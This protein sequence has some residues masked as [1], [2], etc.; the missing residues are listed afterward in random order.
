M[1]VKIVVKFLASRVRKTTN[2]ATVLLGFHLK[3]F[4]TFDSSLHK[5]IELRRFLAGRK[6]VS[7]NLDNCNL[8]TNTWS[9][10]TSNT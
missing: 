2:T 6:P 8:M 4:D 9:K 7:L 1:R 3:L 5:N 10:S